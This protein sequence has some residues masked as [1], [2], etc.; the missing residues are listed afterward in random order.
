MYVNKNIKESSSISHI[1]LSYEYVF[2][3][4]PAFPS[5]NKLLRLSVYIFQENG[6]SGKCVRVLF[7]S[8]LYKRFLTL[9]PPL[10]HTH[11][12]FTMAMRSAVHKGRFVKDLPTT[13]SDSIR[14]KRENTRQRIREFPVWKRPAINWSFIYKGGSRKSLVRFKD[15]DQRTQLQPGQAH[16]EF[17][18]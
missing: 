3:I 11:K 15:E 4:P 8:V 16:R 10:I 12:H 14:F 2:Y 13:T 9:F 7:S 1:D 5:E 18:L 17:R 6:S